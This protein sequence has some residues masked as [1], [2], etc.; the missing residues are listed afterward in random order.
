MG[1]EPETDD[2]ECARVA[3]TSFRSNM[4]D[5]DC[6]YNVSRD[7]V[8]GCQTPMLF[9]MGSDPYHPEVT[10]REIADLAP[11]ATLVEQW[12]NAADDGTVQVALDFLQANTP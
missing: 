6:V 3:W 8:A 7:F 9:L 2:A 12:K 4:Y 10:S 11:N 5:H 1:R